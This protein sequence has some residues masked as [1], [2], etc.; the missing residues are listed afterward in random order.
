MLMEKS[1]L[2]LENSALKEMVKKS[3]EEFFPTPSIKINLISS[4]YRYI[5]NLLYTWS[6][7]RSWGQV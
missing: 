7:V 2:L 5:R 4:A 1:M 3:G 6:S